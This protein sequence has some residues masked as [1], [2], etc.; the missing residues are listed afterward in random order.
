MG[1]DARLRIYRRR[2]RISL[3]TAVAVLLTMAP[4]AD[5]NPLS[6]YRWKNR[7]IIASLPAGWE[8]R[9]ERKA[10]E[11]ALKA[12]RVGVLDR[13][14]LVI[15]VSPKKRFIDG[16]T[17]LPDESVAEIRDR[18]S[19]DES[20]GKPIFVLVGKDGGA[21]ARQTGKLDLDRFFVLID[22][23]PMRKREM[24]QNE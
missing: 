16:A 9:E 4:T 20:A 23:M 13:D 3:V 12:K 7:L 10:V 18:F 19:L 5:A 11:E 8:H 2:S 21:K 15:D 1:N 14:L 22:T 24:R 6:D 17:R